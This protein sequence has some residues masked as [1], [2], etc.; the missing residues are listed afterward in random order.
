[1][2]HKKLVRLSQQVSDLSTFASFYKFCRFVCQVYNTAGNNIVNCTCRLLL[3]AHGAL[4]IMVAT[5][6]KISDHISGL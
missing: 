4:A 3:T 2:K 1:M 6:E 5:V